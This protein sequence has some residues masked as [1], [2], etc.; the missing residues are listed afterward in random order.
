ME[1]CNSSM[2]FVHFVF[3]IYCC[4]SMVASNNLHVLCY[5]IV[6][7]DDICDIPACDYLIGGFSMKL[8]SDQIF[9][10]RPRIYQL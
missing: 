8:I 1:A 4:L 7:V 5:Y 6:I 3:S 10:P 2:R 9:E